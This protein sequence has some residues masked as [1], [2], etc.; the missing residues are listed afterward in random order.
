[1]L[2]ELAAPPVVPPPLDSLPPALV[3]PPRLD[4]PPLV[5]SEID[6]VFVGARI[7]VFRFVELELELA[8]SAVVMNRFALVDGVEVREIS[9]ADAFVLVVAPPSE[10]SE[11]EFGGLL[12]LRCGVAG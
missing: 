4:P 8:M 3:P 12:P 6:P 10:L 1:M 11:L 5:A 2:L 9:N 7:A